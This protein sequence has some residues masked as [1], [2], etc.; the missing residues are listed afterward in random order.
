M[1]IVILTVTLITYLYVI[2]ILES[3]TMEQLRKHTVE[4]G[5][6][7]TTLFSLLETGSYNMLFGVSTLTIPIHEDA[8]PELLML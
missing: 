2:S 5:Q 4:R 1:S 6:R 8:W 7:E 3:Q